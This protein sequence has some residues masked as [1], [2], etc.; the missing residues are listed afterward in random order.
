MEPLGDTAIAASACDP[1]GALR[2][3]GWPGTMLG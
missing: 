2:D 3:A 1:N